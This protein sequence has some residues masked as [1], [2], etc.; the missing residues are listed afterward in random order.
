ML[1]LFGFVFPDWLVVTIGVLWLSATVLGILFSV[2]MFIDSLPRKFGGKWKKFLWSV[3]ILLIPF[4]S[5][6]YYYLY[7]TNLF[8]KK[9]K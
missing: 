2:S 7:K 4:G 5:L 1:D 3:F 8:S 9:R 6:V